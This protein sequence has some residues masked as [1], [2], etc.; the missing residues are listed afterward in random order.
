MQAQGSE[1]TIKLIGNIVREEWKHSA[2][3]S[4]ARDLKK[5]RELKIRDDTKIVK[6]E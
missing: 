1:E 5:R 2:N 4:H 6:L 3:I